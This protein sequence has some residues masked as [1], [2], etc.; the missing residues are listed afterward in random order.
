MSR[1]YATV[2]WLAELEWDTQNRGRLITDQWLP[3]KEARDNVLLQKTEVEFRTLQQP[4]GGMLLWLFISI[5]HGR[6]IATADQL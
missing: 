5:I 2:G 6:L 4:K 1:L 3:C